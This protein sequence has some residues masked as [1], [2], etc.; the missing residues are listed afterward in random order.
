MDLRR[1]TEKNPEA[2]CDFYNQ[3]RLRSFAKEKTIPVIAFDAQHE[4]VPQDEGMQV[5][6]AKFMGLS[7]RLEFA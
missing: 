1:M 2:N 6:D 4:H 3:S 7:K 5:D